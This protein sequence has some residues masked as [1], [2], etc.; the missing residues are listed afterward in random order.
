LERKDCYTVEHP[1]PG[2]HFVPRVVSSFLLGLEFLFHFLHLFPD[3]DVIRPN[4]IELTDAIRSFVNLSLPVVESWSLRKQENAEPKDECKNET[5]IHYNPPRRRALDAFCS[6]IDKACNKD[7]DGD[8]KPIAADDSAS[9][10][11]RTTFS[12]VHGHQD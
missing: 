4:A 5:D 3:N 8:E 2:E 11:G 9:D 1:A 6:K 12:L 10:V 7:S